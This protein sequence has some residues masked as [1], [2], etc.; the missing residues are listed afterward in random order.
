MHATSLYESQFRHM[1]YEL[2]HIPCAPVSYNYCYS[3]DYDVCTCLLLGRPCRLEALAAFSVDINLQ[4]LLKT[5]L[6]LGFP[7]PKAR[8]CDGLVVRSEASIL[9]G[10]DYYDDIPYDDFD[11]SSHF[12]SPL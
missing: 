7:T 5:N 3:F 12:L 11:V 9:L 4:S 6:S 8:S 1:S 2:S 10:H